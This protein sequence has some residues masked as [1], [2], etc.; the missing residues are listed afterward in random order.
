MIVTIQV[1]QEDIDSGQRRDACDCPVWRAIA[2]ALP[3][4]TAEGRYFAVGPL[5]VTFSGYAEY[6]SRA[7]LPSIAEQFMGR[8]D[9]DVAVE[10]LEFELAIPDAIADLA[11]TS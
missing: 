11:G 7:H 3:W 10:P 5:G 6:V 2:R 9:E 4:L 1:A 8:F